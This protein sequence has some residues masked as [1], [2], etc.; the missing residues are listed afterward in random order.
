MIIFCSFVALGTFVDF[1]CSLQS[2]HYQ[3][4]LADRAV[5][6]ILHLQTFSKPTSN[7]VLGVSEHLGE[8]ATSQF[9]PINALFLD[10]NVPNLKHLDRG[11]AQILKMSSQ[12]SR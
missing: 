2:A 8:F 3:T 9:L 4:L 6:T 5:S 10:Q 1:H 7:L 11:A 12:L